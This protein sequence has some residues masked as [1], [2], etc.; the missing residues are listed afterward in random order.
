MGFLSGPLLRART[1]LI[2]IFRTS[3]RRRSSQTETLP[4]KC[5]Q[6]RR[7]VE[8]AL[9]AGINL[10]YPSFKRVFGGPRVWSKANYKCKSHVVNIVFHLFDPTR[11]DRSSLPSR[12]GGGTVLAHIGVGESLRTGCD[13]ASSGTSRCSNP[14]QEGRVIAGCRQIGNLA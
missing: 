14:D 4:Q 9:R 12:I 2:V 5:Q 10:L 3:T 1:W 8:S 7:R 13:P 6:L 11:Q